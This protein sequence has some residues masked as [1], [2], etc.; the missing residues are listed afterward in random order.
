MFDGLWGV[1]RGGLSGWGGKGVL[2]AGS[3]G[4]GGGMRVLSLGVNVKSE[5]R[6]KRTSDFER[7]NGVGGM[8]S[9]SLGRAVAVSDEG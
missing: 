7:R 2:L 8:D 4:G 5:V 9:G 6:A 1:V 3:V